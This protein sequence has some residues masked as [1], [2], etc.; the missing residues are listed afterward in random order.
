MNNEIYVLSRL[1]GE[2]NMK[3]KGLLLK[4]LIV[5][6]L[7]ISGCSDD[8]NNNPL[9]SKPA[10]GV[11]KE[12][13]LDARTDCYLLKNI[14]SGLAAGQNHTVSVTCHN[15]KAPMQGLFFMYSTANT[16]HHFIY[17]KDGESFSF[18]PIN[19]SYQLAPLY[20]D[21][22][23]TSDNSGTITINITGATSKT[24]QLDARK[25][26]VLLDNIT[27]IIGGLNPNKTQ[28]VEV[29][30]DNVKAPMQG[31][32]FMYIDSNSNHKFRFVEDGDYFTFRPHTQSRQIAPIYV[33]WSTTSDN[34]GKINIIISEQ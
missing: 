18:K 4:L 6:I 16:G 27:D 32:F 8:S 1:N 34:S 23:T 21:W 14:I 9:E 10:E 3:V 25:D 22:S 33:D 19:N 13:Q 29:S 24:I 26:A 31:L 28:K 5:I 7:I 20:V 17:V 11:K 2:N 30:L 15:V 12:I